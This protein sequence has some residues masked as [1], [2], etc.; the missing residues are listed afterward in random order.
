M[1]GERAGGGYP[2]SRLAGWGCA[3]VLVASAA[4]HG[5]TAA[6]W[7][8]SIRGQLPRLPAAAALIM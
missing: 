2:I 4:W 7:L 8:P 5:G 3:A 1:A 6:T